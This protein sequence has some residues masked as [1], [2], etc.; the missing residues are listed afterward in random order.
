M[1]QLFGGRLLYFLFLSA[2]AYC[3]TSQ[4]WYILVFG[5]YYVSKTYTDIVITAIILLA[6]PYTVDPLHKGPVPLG[7]SCR[8]YY[9]VTMYFFPN[10][11][12]VYTSFGFGYSLVQCSL[13]FSYSLRYDR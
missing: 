4:F 9:R 12:K 1:K 5:L 8:A 3:N 2:L 7:Y 6:C 13:P 10:F 11:Y